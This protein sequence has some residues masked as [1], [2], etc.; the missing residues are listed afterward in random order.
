MQG[1]Q[2]NGRSYYRCKFPAEYA[3]TEHR[4]AKTVYVREAAIVPA[5]DQWI[6]ELFTDDSIDDTCAAIAASFEPDPATEAGAVATRKIKECDVKLER[7][8]QALEAGTDASIVGGWIEEVTLERKA[9]VFQL[10]RTHGNARMTGEEI[11]SLVEQ[12]KGLVALLESADP[13]DRRAVY[14]E[15]NV[16]IEFHTDGRLH[17]KAGPDVCTNDRV[18]GGT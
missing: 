15:L 7:Y 13:A 4:H 5:I 10:R 1:S 16:S 2:N 3:V 12:L 8:R 17:V 18:G 14:Q 11:R 6:A 9:A